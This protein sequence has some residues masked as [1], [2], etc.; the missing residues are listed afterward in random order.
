MLN[1][2]KIFKR[3]YSGLWAIVKYEGF[4]SLISM[5]FAYV[6][7]HLFFTQKYYMNITD[8][9]IKENMNEREFLPRINNYSVKIIST[10]KEADNLIA[11]GYHFGAYEMRLRKAL[12]KDIIT[13][14][15]FVN[16]E[17]ANLHCIAYGQKGTEDVDFRL[18]PVNF[19]KKEVVVG[20][21]FT[22]PKYRRLGL[23]RYSGYILKEYCKKYG[24]IRKVAGLTANNYPAIANAA[25]EPD[26]KIV[27]IGRYIRILW[28]K[29]SKV[30][31]IDPITA[32]ELLD[33]GLN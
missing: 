30:K 13:F 21:A 16:K 22:V 12:D 6:L 17:I 8:L 19:E 1:T 26:L 32:K 10:N 18:L 2:L 31:K 5:G 15:V 27:A 28:F 24:Y 3:K 9:T 4:K 7:A 29:Y 25:K 11:K 14:C 23:R 20:R 33:Q